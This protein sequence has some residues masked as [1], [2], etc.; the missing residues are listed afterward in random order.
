[1]VKEIL[2]IGGRDCIVQGSCNAT[3]VL[4]QPVDGHD[5]EELDKL[6]AY[7]LAHTA[8]SFLHVAVP[9]KRWN[10]ELTP[11]QAPPVFG[12]IPFGNGA[13]ATLFYIER[14]LIPFLNGAYCFQNTTQ[15]VLGG[16]SL[17]GLFALWVAYQPSVF[18]ATVSAS[19]SAWYKDWL[20]YAEQHQPKVSHIYL[21]LGDTEDHTKTKIMQ[22]IKLDVY[23]LAEIFKQKGVDTILEWNAGNHFQDNGTRTAKGFV[24]AMKSIDC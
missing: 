3:I 20:A 6:I 18:I 4:I 23:R 17:A 5:I 10:E 16:Y 15:F 2:T 11:W 9:I 12:K 8:Q 24:W 14:E 1:M 22:T 19:P 13:S 7:L 21:S